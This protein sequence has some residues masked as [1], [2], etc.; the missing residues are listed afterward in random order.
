M[1]VF[2][3]IVFAFLSRDALADLY[4]WV[5]PES[6]SVKYSSYPPPWYGDPEKEKRAP[7]VEHI[8]E[9]K[10]AATTPVPAPATA[11]GLPAGAPAGGAAEGGTSLQSLEARRKQLLQQLAS[12]SMQKE[13]Q[14]GGQALKAQLDTFAAVNNEMD[15][16][17]PRGAST[18]RI[19]AQPVLEKLV[20]D[21]RTQLKAPGR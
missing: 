8:P 4:R 10:P 9:R 12:A 14:A 20:E 18:R 15:R 17:D 7:R 2:L 21:L 19:E 11:N 13:L 16:L 6:G 5:D 3:S 1:R